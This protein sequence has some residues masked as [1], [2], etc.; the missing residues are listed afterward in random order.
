MFD[1]PVLRSLAMYALS[2]LAACGGVAALIHFVDEV[3]NDAG[4]S[5]RAVLPAPA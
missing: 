2:F 1:D 5:L 3:R 4:H